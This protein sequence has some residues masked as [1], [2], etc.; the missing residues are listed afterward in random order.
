MK[1]LSWRP[2]HRAYSPRAIT[3]Y[4]NTDEYNTP[5]PSWSPS[6]PALPVTPDVSLSPPSSRSHSCA[7]RHIR[8]CMPMHRAL[9]PLRVPPTG[10]AC[11]SDA[12]PPPRTPPPPAEYESTTQATDQSAPA[13][14][15]RSHRRLPHTSQ[16]HSTT[17]SIPHI[18]CTR[19]WLPGTKIIVNDSS[20]F[21]SP[22]RCSASSSRRTDIS[23]KHTNL[24]PSEISRRLL[25]IT[26]SY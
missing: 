7:N 26:S 16:V 19:S 11:P 13:D 24:A 4:L 23:P 9:K 5:E 21:N 1:M 10:P 6:P 17:E 22:N 15:T 14:Q 20:R 2:Y 18:G 25:K 12:D 3:A 8:M